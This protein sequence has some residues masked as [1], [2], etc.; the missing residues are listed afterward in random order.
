MRRTLYEQGEWV[1]EASAYVKSHNLNHEE[2]SAHTHFA[3]CLCQLTGISNVTGLPSFDFF[4]DGVPA[5]VVEVF[6]EN[7]QTVIDLV[8]WP[9]NDPTRFATAVGE[10]DMLGIAPH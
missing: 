1:P 8:A 9:L 3:V 2:I 4:P 10:A 5:A 6:A 7:A